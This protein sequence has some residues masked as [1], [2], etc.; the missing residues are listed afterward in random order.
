[1]LLAS[2][3]T[4]SALRRRAYSAL[5]IRVMRA[6]SARA[7]QPATRVQ[8][9]EGLGAGAAGLAHSVKSSRGAMRRYSM[10]SI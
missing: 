1:M 8:C 6:P 10:T 4:I 7:W 5:G 9:N 3:C 2:I